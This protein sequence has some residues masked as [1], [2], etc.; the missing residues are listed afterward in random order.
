MQPTIAVG[1][2]STLDNLITFSSLDDFQKFARDYEGGLAE[3]VKTG[4]ETVAAGSGGEMPIDGERDEAQELLRLAR[5]SGAEISHALGGN[6]AQEAVTLERLGSESIYLGGIFPKIFSN[7]SSEDRSSLENVDTSYALT[8]E[9][10]RPASYI[11]Q[12]PETNR[13]ILAE[14]EG[15]RIEQLRPYL[16]G[17]PETIREVTGA[18]GELDIVSLVGW[19]VLFGNGLSEDD[20]QL[21]ARAIKG[22]RKRT[23]AFLFTDAGGIGGLTGEEREKIWS[24]YSLFDVLSVN[25]DEVFQVSDVLTSGQEDEFQAMQELLEEG[26]DLFTVWLHTPDFQATLSSEFSRGPLEE[27]QENAALAGLYKVEE[28]GYPTTSDLSTLRKDR[29]FSEKGLEKSE[30]FLDQY[31]EEIEGRR[32]VVSPCYEPE[33]F[34][35]TLG[36]GD[37]SAA[38]Y[39]HSIAASG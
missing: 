27:A 10:Y 26:E 37:V 15:R 23:D 4:Y 17:L 24:I 11:L 25:E 18:Y 2:E 13:Y 22:V 36:A 32:L 30:A 29:S 19:Q 7:L 28:G 14:G 3:Q 5:K 21:V 38:A 6:G 35:S 16:R 34:V 31:G 33:R 9:V 12:A 39:L 1:L 8:F 20:F